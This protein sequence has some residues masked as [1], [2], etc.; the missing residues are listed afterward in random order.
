M[1]FTKSPPSSIALSKFRKVKSSTGSLEI[2]SVR[3]SYLREKIQLYFESKLLDL[4]DDVG[5]G[6]DSIKP[7]GRA[8]PST[9]FEYSRCCVSALS[10]FVVVDV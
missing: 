4:D 10:L 5:S 1:N 2:S 6:E 8:R 7:T 3:G 9:V